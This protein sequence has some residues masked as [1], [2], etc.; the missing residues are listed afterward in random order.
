MNNMHIIVRKD[1]AKTFLFFAVLFFITSHGGFLKYVIVLLIALVFVMRYK[2]NLSR[3]SLYVLLP[4]CTYI[5]FGLVANIENGYFDF[6]TVKQALLLFSPVAAAIGIYVAFYRLKMDICKYVFWGIACVNAERLS[7]F[8]RQDLLESEYAF[9]Y[10]AFLI[11]FFYKKEWKYLIICSI[12][13][14]LADKRISMGAAIVCL[15]FFFL[16]IRS[17]KIYFIGKLF[18]P[19]ISYLYI[20][21]VKNDYINTLFFK[22]HIN[23]MGR[24]DMWRNFARYYAINPNFLG[25]GMGWVRTKLEEINSVA[26]GNLHNDLLASFLEIGFIGFGVWLVSYL[27]MIRWIECKNDVPY[28]KRCLLLTLIVYTVINYM[29]DNI[30]IYISYWLP[31][32]LIILDVS[33]KEISVEMSAWET[34]KS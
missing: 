21:I 26:F 14:V 17:K 24:V 27:I 8:T 32:S 9:I 34:H 29:T 4:P 22:Y 19:I 11:Y 13:F 15:C 30:L 12:L 6:N 33:K 20:Y 31:L 25:L 23:S 18:L 1:T 7:Q 16:S 2:N 28:E 3:T 10:G 5:L